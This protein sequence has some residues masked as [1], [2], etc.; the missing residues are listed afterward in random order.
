MGVFNYDVSLLSSQAIFVNTRACDSK[1][2]MYTASMD[3]VMDIGAS[4]LL[5]HSKGNLLYSAATAQSTMDYLPK[6]VEDEVVD[7]LLSREVLVAVNLPSPLRGK[8]MVKSSQS[9]WRDSNGAQCNLYLGL[10]LHPTGKC[11][12]YYCYFISLPT[13][14]KLFPSVVDYAMKALPG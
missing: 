10:S 6:A 14:L 1:R 11:L 5:Q 2:D 4:A 7:N 12:W 9:N 13:A 3:S 8:A